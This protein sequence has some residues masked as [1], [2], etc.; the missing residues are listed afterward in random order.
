VF[1]KGNL[2][3][4]K[5]L[6]AL[7]G[8]KANTFFGTGESVDAIR[9]Y[10]S[11]AL[12]VVLSP[13]AGIPSAKEF[14]REH[15]I[16]YITAELP[17]GPTGTAEFLRK[18]AFALKLD[19][20]AVESVI[21]EE[22]AY[23]YSFVERIVDIYSDLDFQRYSI[24]VADSYLAHP[25]TRFLTNDLGWVPYLTAINDI[26]DEQGQAEYTARFDDIE[27][28]TRPTVVYETNAS[29]V[30]DIV[31]QNWPRNHNEKYYNALAPVYV[32]GSVIERGLAEKL[33]AGLL[34]VA[35]PVSNRVILNKTIVGLH[36][37]LTL[38]EDL[39]TNLVAAR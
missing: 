19:L 35:F 23:Y 11:A 33:G 21:S 7:V 1:F 6:L 30:I 36:G 2:D 26:D 17:I 32:V 14:E 18:I 15:G 13:I 16:P 27:S 8:V 3:E 20:G 28:E 12:N 24:V 39:I 22:T 10:G 29:E 9:K 25:I 31:R 38:V 34:T 37:A 4:L 5:R